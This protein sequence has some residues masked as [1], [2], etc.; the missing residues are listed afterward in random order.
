MQLPAL[1]F[2][3]IHIRDENWL[4]AAALY[5]PHISRIVPS[6]YPKHDSRTAATFVDADV[7]RDENPG[8]LFQSTASHFLDALN[9]NLDAVA[10]RYSVDQTGNVDNPTGLN[11]GG[12]WQAPNL[13][14]IHLQKFPP[15]IVELLSD[16]R[17]AVR[18]RG[19][20][21]N[22][23]NPND[24]IGLHPA[25][26]GAYMT[27]LANQISENGAF[28]PLTDQS[29]LRVATPNEDVNSAL[30]LLLGHKPHTDLAAPAG[31]IE[32]YVM[33]AMQQVLPANLDGVTPEK[34]IEV[35][36]KLDAELDDF[37]RYVTG[38][39]QEL[40]ALSQIPSEH[41]RLERFTSHVD[42]T[43]KGP[44]ER[45]ERGLNKNGIETTVALVMTSSVAPPALAEG[46]FHLAGESLPSVAAIGI[47]T[48][49]LIGS[50]WWGTRNRRQDAKRTS[51]VGYLLDVRKELNPATALGRARQ[52]VSGA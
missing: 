14:W 41:H 13:A 3:Y 10:E 4:K 21:L 8:W 15:Q 20:W 26:A 18:G 43:I 23:T 46:A 51:P 34:I 2:P 22:H 49:A 38:M 11:A 25:L 45:L 36:R 39:Q 24:W 1:Y 33:L 40:V 52:I 6:E 28:E 7:L 27:A 30:R 16:R 47:G 9:E 5:W 37:R 17:V 48:V 12:E 32:N 35:R 42:T 50:A 44:L 31:A 19:E 29:D